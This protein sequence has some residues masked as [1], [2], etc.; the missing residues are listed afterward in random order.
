MT[1]ISMDSSTEASLEEITTNQ[2]EPVSGVIS[3]QREA[4]M[5]LFY[6]PMQS[7]GLACS[8]RMGSSGNEMTYRS[9]LDKFLTEY[10][11]KIPYCK[12]LYVLNR[13]GVQISSSMSREGLLVE[14]CGRDRSD[15]PY[16]REALS[17]AAFLDKSR[18]TFYQQW[19]YLDETTQAVD[20]LLC[21]AYISQHALRPSMT[22]IMF[23]RDHDGELL[24]FVGADFALRDLPQSNAVYKEER[25]AR[26]FSVGAG[27]SQATSQREH[28]H[29][30]LDQNLTTVM[31]VLEELIQFHGVFHVKLHFSSSQ[32]VIWQMDD[33]YRYRILSISDL[34][35]P[36]TCLAYPSRTYPQSAMIRRDEVRDILEYLGR[37]RMQNDAIYLRSGSVNIYNGM[38]GISFSS[39]GSHYIPHEQFLKT[40]LTLWERS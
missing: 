2:P 3:R 36:D 17:V 21:D 37:L 12:Y 6:R 14:H 33:P 27:L 9:E 32:A 4:L 15:R 11:N 1:S 24:G 5:K 19:P 30:R 16:M 29:S 23:V 28:Y 34:L 13:E 7:I 38:I 35:D 26:H 18:E 8:Q 39:E 10:F 31:S 22:A 25:R 40:D 20:F